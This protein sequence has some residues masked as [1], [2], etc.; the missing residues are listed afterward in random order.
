MIKHT[1]PVAASLL[2]LLFGFKSNTVPLKD[3]K[4]AKPQ[5]ERLYFPV[6]LQNELSES[7]NLFSKP[8]NLFFST[9]VERQDYLREFEQYFP[10]YSE[11]LV[12]N[13]ELRTRDRSAITIY[14]VDAKFITNILNNPAN[15][16]PR[17]LSPVI[18]SLL[19]KDV[20][21]GK[22]IADDIP[23]PRV[24]ETEEMRL[25][26]MVSAEKPKL[27]PSKARAT[28]GSDN[29]ANSKLIKDLFLAKLKARDA[30]YIDSKF[31]APVFLEA[32]LLG[33]GTGDIEERIYE[34]AFRWMI[35]AN[36]YPKHYEAVSPVVKKFIQENNFRGLFYFCQENLNPANFQVEIQTIL[37]QYNL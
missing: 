34:F 26:K 4:P 3:K 18:D 24:Q 13:K 31:S 1:I 28:D 17:K 2:F 25:A 11:G 19:F 15:K 33:D 16:D 35:F 29:R 7:I 8:A 30:V 37:N 9:H 10:G 5:Y 22:D 23:A 12:S 36:A 21:L 14:T 32:S 6:L 20:F 27:D